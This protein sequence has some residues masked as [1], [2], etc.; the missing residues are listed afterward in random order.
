MQLDSVEPTSQRGDR[1][2]RRMSRVR[3][4]AVG[5]IKRFVVLFL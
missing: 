3:E 1:A 4:R 2:H 5:E